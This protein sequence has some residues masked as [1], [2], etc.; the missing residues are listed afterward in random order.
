MNYTIFIRE[1]ITP[2]Y[3]EVREATGTSSRLN[4]GTAPQYPSTFVRMLYSDLSGIYGT[5]PTFRVELWEDPA[6]SATI[7][8][9]RTSCPGF[10]QQCLINIRLLAKTHLEAKW[11]L[12]AQINCS[13]GIYS[14]AVCSQCASD[15]A[16]VID[17]SNTAEDAVQAAATITDLLTVTPQFP[18]I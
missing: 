7:N 6:G 12:W 11:P 15:I 16:S 14:T 8:Q 17:A 9:V 2:Q 18:E 10:I 5:D 13:L 1:Q 3:I 4:P